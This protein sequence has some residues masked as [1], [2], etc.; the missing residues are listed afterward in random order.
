MKRLIIIIGLVTITFGSSA[1]WFSIPNL[2]TFDDCTIHFGFTLGINTFDYKFMHYNTLDDNPLFEYDKVEERF[3][4][5]IDSVGRAIR[6][7]IPQLIP[8]FTVGIVSNLR[9]TKNLDLRFVPGLSFGDR[10]IA[11]N[12]P[13]HDINDPAQAD[14]FIVRST[15]IDLPI[16]LKYKSKRIINHRPYMMGGVAFR[17]DIS[18]SAN[19]ELLLIDKTGFFAEVGMGWDL[20]LQFFRLSTEIKYSIGLGN[21][22]SDKLPKLPQQQYYQMSLQNMFQNMLTLSFHFE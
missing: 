11:F 8:G 15:F 1:Q 7:D 3:R 14:A 5:E 16:Y 4:P 21:I 6:A 10:R 19:D 2:T 9:L 17:W 13:I 12:V 18:K 22:L 20:Y